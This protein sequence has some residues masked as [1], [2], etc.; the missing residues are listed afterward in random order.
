MI[1]AGEA[2]KMSKDKKHMNE[3]K[4]SIYGLCEQVY[5]AK[6]EKAAQEGKDSL[7]IYADAV[8][9]FFYKE[10]LCKFGFTVKR[11][12]LSRRITIEW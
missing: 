12:S 1:T 3:V 9:A 4:E 5:S 6:I 2:R 10:Y 8:E 7:E 11:D